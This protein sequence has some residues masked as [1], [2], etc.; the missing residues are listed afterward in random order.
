MDTFSFFY[1][2]I[3]GKPYSGLLPIKRHLQDEKQL[4]AITI[5]VQ[6]IKAPIMCLAGTDDHIQPAVFFT[7]RMEK[8]LQT[9]FKDKNRYVYYENA[10]HF[11]AYPSSLP[12]LLQT[13]GDT[14]YK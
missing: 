2:W 14:N 7:K 6:D 3:F 9:P 10:S 12:H 5:R 11:S 1:H 13:T 8:R 4:D